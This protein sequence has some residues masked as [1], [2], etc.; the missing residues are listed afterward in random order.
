MQTAKTMSNFA[1]KQT[2]NLD[3]KPY[4][5]QDNGFSQKPFQGSLHWS[6]YSVC[7]RKRVLQVRKILVRGQ[8]DQGRIRN[9]MLHC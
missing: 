4:E 3:S 2:A 6:R 9:P 1:F 8:A 5:E 7:A